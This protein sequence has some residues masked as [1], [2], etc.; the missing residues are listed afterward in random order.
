MAGCRPSV[1]SGTYLSIV[2]RLTPSSRA[3]EATLLPDRLRMSR[4]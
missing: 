4:A 1:S 3:I 2:D